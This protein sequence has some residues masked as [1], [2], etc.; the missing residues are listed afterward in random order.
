MNIF[1]S[2]KFIAE[3]Y[4]NDKV[5]LIAKY[6]EIGYRDAV[7]TFD[8]VAKFEDA[9]VDVYLTV[10]EGKKYYFR[11]INWAGNTV[12]PSE[13]LGQLLSINRG[14]VYNLKQLNKRLSEDEDAVS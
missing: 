3:E 12:Y 11:D 8:S 5:S 7:I 1:R 2:K 9:K 14:D 6:N 10:D 4:K 13:Y